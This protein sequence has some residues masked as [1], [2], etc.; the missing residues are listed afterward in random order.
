M[1]NHVIFG[2]DFSGM[3]LCTRINMRARK[4]IRLTMALAGM[5]SMSWH[6]GVSTDASTFHRMP[7]ATDLLLKMH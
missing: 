3:G 1:I 4:T 2:L 5:I 7:S 6:A